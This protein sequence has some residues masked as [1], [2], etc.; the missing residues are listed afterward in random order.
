MIT[1]NGKVKD[2]DAWD[3]D[4]QSLKKEVRKAFKKQKR[5]QLLSSWE[6]YIDKKREFKQKLRKAKADN[7][8]RFTESC[9]GPKDMAKLF[10]SVQKKQNS[11][12]SVLASRQRSPVNSLNLLMDTHF[13]GST[14]AVASPVSSGE[15]MAFPYH[16]DL[17]FISVE[18]VKWSIQQFKPDKAAGPD[19]IKPIVL[20]QL[21]PKMLKRLTIL[22]R[23]S[24]ALGYVP[25]KLRESKVIFLPKPG[26]SDYSNPRAYRPISLTSC[27][28]K[29]LERVL[30]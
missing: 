19:G 27:V 11:H 8:R 21:G 1:L 10:K 29:V 16:T 20:Q 24:V 7:W 22:Y 26:K 25:G 9:S 3:S 5:D 30:L 14:E 12:L 28:F 23:A 18:R 17:D 13:P 6:E 15:A 4:I 2:Q